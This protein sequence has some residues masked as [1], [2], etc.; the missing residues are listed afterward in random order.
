MPND[1]TF[2]V[3]GCIVEMQHEP[4]EQISGKMALHA[5]KDISGSQYPFKLQT[6][7]LEPT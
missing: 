2:V 5:K 3:H 6:A 7:P 4:S 1:D